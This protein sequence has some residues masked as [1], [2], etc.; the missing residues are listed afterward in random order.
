MKWK[1]K[2]NIHAAAML[3]LHIL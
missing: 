3:I 1:V 2:Y